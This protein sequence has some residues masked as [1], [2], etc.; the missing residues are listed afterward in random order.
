[1]QKAGEMRKAREMQKAGGAHTW[2]ICIAGK[3]AAA[4]SSPLMSH[5]KQNVTTLATTGEARPRVI[6]KTVA[7]RTLRVW[8]SSASR[9]FLI[10]SR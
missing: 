9:R 6:E 5:S 4:L 8:T 7:R 10:S 3:T 1:M 2:K